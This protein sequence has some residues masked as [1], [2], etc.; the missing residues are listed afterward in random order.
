MRIA[1]WKAPYGALP[2]I[3][4]P[5][6]PFLILNSGNFLLLTLSLFSMHCAGFLKDCAS[7]ARSF[8]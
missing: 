5:R 2:A 4:D 8:P 3:C 7:K 1:K 6:F